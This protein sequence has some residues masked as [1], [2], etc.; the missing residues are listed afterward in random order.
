MN[1]RAKAWAIEDI[2]W[3]QDIDLE[4]E[5]L[6]L[7]DDEFISMLSSRQKSALSHI[8]GLV[9]ISAIS[10][11]ENVI[12]DIK[13]G[14]WQRL[15]RNKQISSKVYNEGMEFFD[16][17][18]KHSQMFNRYIS[19]YLSKINLKKEEAD[20]FLP[21]YDKKSIFMR[22]AKFNMFLGGR[23]IWWLVASVEN[24]SLDLFREI[25]KRKRDIDPLYYE[26][27]LK[28]FQEE[29]IHSS[30]AENLI[31]SDDLGKSTF[32]NRIDYIIADFLQITWALWQLVRL[33][34][35]QKHESRHSFIKDF[36]S[37]YSVI[38]QFGR[39]RFLKYMFVKFPYLSMM[40]NSHHRKGM[41]KLLNKSTTVAP[42]RP[43]SF[44]GVFHVG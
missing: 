42:L 5:L 6:T 34:K 41:I 20:E 19:K 3:H 10:A 35:I 39:I 1:S 21:S 22:L 13:S 40:L 26:I 30:F 44:K 18:S 4:K 38:K 23:A 36:V 16:D 37:I 12:Q 24:E 25:H 28:H 32:L 7:E 17:E 27:H 2:N 31:L 9:I 8:M 15:K 33:S 43:S 11:H 29:I 14:H